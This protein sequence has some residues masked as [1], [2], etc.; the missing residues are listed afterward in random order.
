[1]YLESDIHSV[2]QRAS[3]VHVPHRWL[4][5]ALSVIGL[6]RHWS[7]ARVR[8]VTVCVLRGNQIVSAERAIAARKRPL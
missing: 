5:A 2:L 4:F 7:T 8:H 6:D 3:D 1:M